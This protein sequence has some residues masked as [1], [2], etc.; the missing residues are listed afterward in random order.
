[1]SDRY[2]E[3][4]DNF[5]NIAPKRLFLSPTDE[6]DAE[7]ADL[8]DCVWSE[9]RVCDADVEYIRAGLARPTP[10][11]A[12]EII[13]QEKGWDGLPVRI[14]VSNGKDS[15]W[16]FCKGHPMA[17]KGYPEGPADLPGAII[18]TP[19]M[20]GLR[21]ISAQADAAARADEDGSPQPRKGASDE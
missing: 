18:T 12:L 17:D 2:D 3:F 16:Y 5:K 20:E 7:V 10:R 21:K 14:H 15:R 11:A 6:D 8:T 19:M 9:D 4:H 13:D 1:M